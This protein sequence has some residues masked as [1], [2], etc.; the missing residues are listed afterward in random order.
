[1]TKKKS[2]QIISGISN[3][4]LIIIGIMG[5][6][7]LVISVVGGYI[8]YRLS[9]PAAPVAVN[10]TLANQGQIEGAQVQPEQPQMGEPSS[11]Y[12]LIW[13]NQEPQ[14]D[15]NPI[16]IP[17]DGD[18]SVWVEFAYA[19]SDPVP[20]PEDL[21]LLLHKDPLGISSP[22]P[23]PNDSFF[24]NAGWLSQTLSD[25]Q[26]YHQVAEGQT[27]GVD[28]AGRSVIRFT[29]SLSG[30][31]CSLESCPDSEIARS[32]Q[33]TGALLPKEWYREDFGV[34]DR[35]N[36]YWLKAK[37]GEGG[38]PDE[39]ANAWF[40]IELAAASTNLPGWLFFAE[41]SNWSPTLMR[42]D[43]TEMKVLW[44]ETCTPLAVLGNGTK[45]LCVAEHSVQEGEI[46]QM[47]RNG[48]NRTR[49][50][51]KYK[52]GT[53]DEV[54]DASFYEYCTQVLSD[55]NQLLSIVDGVMSAYDLTAGSYLW[56]LARRTDDG[57][58]DK[59]ISAAQWSPN[60][61]VIA[62]T[63]TN[64]TD[65]WEEISPIPMLGDG[66][67]DGQVVNGSGGPILNLTDANGGAPRE[68]YKSL[69]KQFGWLRWSPDS[70]LLAYV[71]RGIRLEPP[72]SLYVS[73]LGGGRTL[74]K[75]FN[76][77]EIKL[78]SWSPDGAKIAFAANPDGEWGV[79]VIAPAGGEPVKLTKGIGADEIVWSPDSAYIIYRE[80]PASIFHIIRADNGTEVMLLDRGARVLWIPDFSK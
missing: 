4:Q 20:N 1:M 52:T 22:G 32:D 39:I 36:G 68:L 5:S 66:S 8:V 70:N 45:F 28:E 47:D 65:E 49:L 59:S 63:E 18:A 40:S 7:L 12:H 35:V 79:Y 77:G 71:E 55:R 13:R 73:D 58:R 48:D 69:D 56:S 16:R 34:Y 64:P 26:T 33:S 50:L 11:Q 60:G 80:S 9:Q 21:V 6:M 67:C 10:P 44:D 27:A 38:N 19:G 51:T 53:Y 31:K 54:L 37:V 30:N 24:H 78:V 41:D 62:F 74:L 76:N 29:F 72:Q 23:T 42:P 14:K 61:Q 17:A 57:Y 75:E 25:G 43:K 15:T 2:N 46:F 3:A